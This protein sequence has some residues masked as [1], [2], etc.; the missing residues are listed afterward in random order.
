MAVRGVDGIDRSDGH[1]ISYVGNDADH[2]HCTLLLQ[3]VRDSD[4]GGVVPP[5]GKVRVDDHTRTGR[6]RRRR[7]RGRHGGRGL[8]PT[9]CRVRRTGGA[10]NQCDREEHGRGDDRS[11]RRAVAECPALAG[12]HRTSSIGQRGGSQHRIKYGILP[13][14]RCGRLHAPLFKEGLAVDYSRLSMPLGE[15]IFTQRSLLTLLAGSSRGLSLVN[16]PAIGFRSSRSP[17]SGHGGPWRC[18]SGSRSP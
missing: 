9:R 8:P 12:R 17:N 4:R 6:S 5:A 16:G 11:R 10:S 7:V 15:V 14:R 13:E 1:R 18:T 3:H 2:V